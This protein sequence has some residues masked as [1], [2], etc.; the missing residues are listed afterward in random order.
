MSNQKR[1]TMRDGT[2]IKIKDMD[3]NHL[4]N[5]IAMLERNHAALISRARDA[6]ESMLMTMQGEMALESV[7]QGLAQLDDS[8]VGDE[9]PIYYDLI[10]EQARRGVSTK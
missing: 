1:W 9:Y 7:E 2:K 3:D 8:D 4:V 5:C 6:G 10:E